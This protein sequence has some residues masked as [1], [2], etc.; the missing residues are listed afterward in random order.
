MNHLLSPAA[1]TFPVQDKF[2]NIQVAFGLSKL[3]YA[4]IA[5]YSHNW[6]IQVDE[7]VSLAVDILNAVQDKVIELASENKKKDNIILDS[8]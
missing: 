4:A 5:L 2:G 6:E 1:P 3:E 8:K 7:A